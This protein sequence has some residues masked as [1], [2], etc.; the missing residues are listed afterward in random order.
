MLQTGAD[1]SRSHW[2]KMFAAQRASTWHTNPVVFQ[3]VCK[4]IAGVSK[5]WVYWLFEDK[6]AVKPATLLS[7]GCGDGSH[8]LIVA[9]NRFAG[10]VEAFDISDI[11][12]ARAQ[13]IADQEGL[14]ATFYT[15]SFDGFIAKPVEKTY[16]A[17]M[18]VGSLHHV[19]NLEGMLDKVRRSLKP[20]GVV[21]YNEHVGPCYIILPEKQVN[22]V[23]TVLAS[24]APEYKHSPNAR[25][26]NPS[27]EVVLEGDPS[28]SV[29]SSLI[30]QFLRFY[31]DVEWE[32]NFGGALLHPLFSL[33]NGEKLADGSPESQSIVNLFIAIEDML[34]DAGVLQSDFCLGIAR[35]RG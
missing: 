20:G 6:L 34:M 30:P 31:F 1:L 19:L 5:H 11:G 25:W 15:D 24:L 4:R 22:V 23:N 26:V 18:F 27:I 35:L 13:Q 21:I 10:H 8:E 32:A 7:I 3:E 17:I 33:L 12:I 14:N 29:R 2:D 16:D 28:E 9:R